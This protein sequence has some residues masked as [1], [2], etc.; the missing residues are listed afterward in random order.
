MRMKKRIL[1]RGEANTDE[2]RILCKFTLKKKK[3]KE[4]S[5]VNFAVLGSGPYYLLGF[6]T[7]RYFRSKLLKRLSC[8]ELTQL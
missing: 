4:K 1:F 8:T 6:T 2:K 5:T 3:K 7:F